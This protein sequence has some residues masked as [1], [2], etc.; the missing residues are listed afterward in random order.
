MKNDK[1]TSEQAHSISTPEGNFSSAFLSAAKEIQDDKCNL[2]ILFNDLQRVFL[3]DIARRY[4]YSEKD[5]NTLE[6]NLIKLQ[7][8][9][10][11]A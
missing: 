10:I 4:A 3:C 6:D 7:Q 5:I 2:F 1:N 11:H 8:I 9:I